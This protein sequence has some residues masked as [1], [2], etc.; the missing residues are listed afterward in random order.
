MRDNISPEEKLLR[1]I[2]GQKKQERTLD[3]KPGLRHSAYPLIQ[4]YFSF[5]Y[6]KKILWMVFGVACI[7]LVV[8]LVYPW[9]Y[10]RKIKLSQIT[11]EKIADSK[12]EPELQPK[13][14]EFY[15]EGIRNRQIFSSPTAQRTDESSGGVNVDSIRDISLVGIISGENP[16]AII[17]DKK[18]Q[19]T[20]YLTKGQFIREF[21]VED[22]Q[23]GR[24]IL[25]CNGQRFEI[26]L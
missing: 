6:I 13:P 21:Q 7:Y 26:Y 4:K 18:T 5:I 3:K 16:Q 8:S 22:I 9:V 24:I 19:K 12:I 1:L 17:E 10:L 23:E 2:R 20:Y 15:L 25:N 11:S 14:Y